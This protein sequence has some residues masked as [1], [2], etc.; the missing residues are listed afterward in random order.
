MKAAVRYLPE[1]QIH[2]L[3]VLKI[4]R[5]SQIPRYVAAAA[6]AP[7]LLIFRSSSQVG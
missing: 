6:E 4:T 3:D 5:P 1:D 2:P 7:D